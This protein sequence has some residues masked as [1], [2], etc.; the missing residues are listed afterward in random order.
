MQVN[1]NGK[2]QEVNEASTLLELIEKL[3]LESKVMAA[4]VEKEVVKKEQCGSYKL[5]KGDSVELLDFVSGR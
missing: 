3:Q 5:L 1:V 2:P 4:A